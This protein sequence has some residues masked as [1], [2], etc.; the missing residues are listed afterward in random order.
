MSKLQELISALPTKI[1]LA[2]AAIKDAI[3][4]HPALSLLSGVL[5]VGGVVAII[6]WWF[7]SDLR[8]AVIGSMLVLVCL[9]FL[10]VY[11][12]IASTLLPGARGKPA[13]GGPLKK[14]L[15]LVGQ[16]MLWSPVLLVVSA[17]VLLNSSVFF[18]KPLPLSYWINRLQLRDAAIGELLTTAI[19]DADRQRIEA[20]RRPLT[21]DT[22][23][24]TLL[25]TATDEKDRSRIESLRQPPISNGPPPVYDGQTIH[26]DPKRTLP[27]TGLYPTLTALSDQNENERYYRTM[28]ALEKWVSHGAQPLFKYQRVLYAVSDGRFK[29]P[30]GHI[31]AKV[32]VSNYPIVQGIAFLIKDDQGLP[33]GIPVKAFRQM[34][35][36]IQCVRSNGKLESAT[37]H[38]HIVRPQ[39]GE[40]LLLLLVVQSVSQDDLSRVESFSIDVNVESSS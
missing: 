12:W 20:L 18:D 13:D 21:R 31:T 11:S 37:N 29:P 17:L 26:V 25:T 8:V 10:L 22:A 30:Y 16:V 9:V 4:L 27:E 35:F 23:I 7:A 3:K 1:Q 34:P 6:A 15:V 33:S 28:N 36:E 2:W 39:L 40:R 14:G 19:D 5:A 24:T 32:A 38:L